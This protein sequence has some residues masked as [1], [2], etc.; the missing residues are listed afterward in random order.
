MTLSAH[1]QHKIYL[2][3]TMEY[4]LGSDDSE[5]VALLQ[6]NQRRDEARS[7]KEKSRD[8][9]SGLIRLGRLFP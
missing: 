1:R 7:R 2:A 3:A 4:S 8:I 5:E 6:A 9:K